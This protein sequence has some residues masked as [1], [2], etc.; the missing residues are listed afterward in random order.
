MDAGENNKALKCKLP[1]IILEVDGMAPLED[2][3]PRD[4]NTSMTFHAGL[5]GGYA[6]EHP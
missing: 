3:C 5:R 6:L 4:C 2:H 1:E